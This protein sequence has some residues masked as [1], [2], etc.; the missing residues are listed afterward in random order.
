MSADYLF[1]KRTL[2][3]T[4][5]LEGKKKKNKTQAATLRHAGPLAK[6]MDAN[7]VL[8]RKSNNS[9]KICRDQP[10]ETLVTSY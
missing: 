6:S 10:G 2:T 7:E 1:L 5:L 9:C 3:I 8:S 4:N